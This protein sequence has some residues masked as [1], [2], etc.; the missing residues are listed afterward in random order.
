MEG[1]PRI[2]EFPE[3][4]GVIPRTIRQI[5]EIK[6]QL[7]EKSWSYKLHVCLVIA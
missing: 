1:G 4:C 2:E 7:V 5:F 6:Q 3:Q